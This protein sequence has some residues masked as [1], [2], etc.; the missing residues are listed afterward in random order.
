[1]N[2][3]F[4]V[5]FTRPGVQTFGIHANGILEIDLRYKRLGRPHLPVVIAALSELPVVKLDLRG[6][7]GKG[8]GFLCFHV[9]TRTTVWRSR[10]SMGGTRRSYS[11][12]CDVRLM[13]HCLCGVDTATLAADNPWDRDSDNQPYDYRS[14]VLR[15]LHDL[16]ELNGAS[17]TSSERESWRA[18]AVPNADSQRAWQRI[19]DSMDLDALFAKARGDGE[20]VTRLPQVDEPAAVYVPGYE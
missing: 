1:M 16:V 9:T 11:L 17:V 2:V 10:Q 12:S 3:C 20:T 19:H 18:G 7:R 4:T 5:P 15:F 6:W 8:G 14:F 13:R